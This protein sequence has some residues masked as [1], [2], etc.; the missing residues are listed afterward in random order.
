[1][2]EYAI[3]SNYSGNPSRYANGW[4]SEPNL[5]LLHG[6]TNN[7]KSWIKIVIHEEKHHDLCDNNIPSE[8]HHLLMY[9]GLEENIKM[10]NKK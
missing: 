2:T 9:M 8:K 7:L 4:F 5:I 3:M 10:V 1:M 6:L